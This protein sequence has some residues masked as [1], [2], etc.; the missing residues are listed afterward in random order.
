M[1][2]KSEIISMVVKCG[3]CKEHVS[4]LGLTLEVESDGQSCPGCDGS[5]GQVTCLCGG[6]TFTKAVEFQCPSCK[7]YGT[8]YL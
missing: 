2:K 3:G 8:I 4:P 1:Y 5:F 6:E 7:Y